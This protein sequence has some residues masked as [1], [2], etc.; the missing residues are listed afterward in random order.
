MADVVERSS[1]ID[2]GGRTGQITTGRIGIAKAILV[3]LIVLVPAAAIRPGV[4]GKSAF[5]SRL[6]SEFNAVSPDYVFIGNS[7]LQSRVDDGVL[8]ARLGQNC[9]FILW[10]GGAESAWTHQALKN[11]VLAAAHRPKR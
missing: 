8:A 1:I 9:C 5:D 10:T 6:L 3:L 2:G 4:H 11:V 7:M